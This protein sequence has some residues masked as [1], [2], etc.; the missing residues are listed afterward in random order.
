[1][2]SYLL[3]D[4]SGSPGCFSFAAARMQR[5]SDHHSH[6]LMSLDRFPQAS[7]GEAPAG[8]AGQSVQGLGY[9]LGRIGDGETDA[10]FSRVD[11]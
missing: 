9:G 1:V 10:L 2:P 7:Q 3:A 6:H 5:Q 4:L 11:R 8:P